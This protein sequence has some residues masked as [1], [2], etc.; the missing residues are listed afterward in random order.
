MPR[1]QP[2]TSAS[3]R[4]RRVFHYCSKC[5]EGQ[6]IAEGDRVTGQWTNAPSRDADSV[7]VC[8]QCEERDRDG[9]C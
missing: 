6:R 7:P 5:S 2:F 3:G 8:P 1:V 9:Q 4:H